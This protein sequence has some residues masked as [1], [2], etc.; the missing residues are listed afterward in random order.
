VC[1][2]TASM[3]IA[4][5]VLRLC[6]GQPAIG[7]E[8]P[9]SVAQ[10]RG[11]LLAAQAQHWRALLSCLFQTRTRIAEWSVCVWVG[12]AGQR[13]NRRR[14]RGPGARARPQHDAAGASHRGRCLPRSAM[15]QTNRIE[16]KRPSHRSVGISDWQR[17]RHCTGS[18]T[19]Q[20][21]GELDVARSAC[22]HTCHQ[23]ARCSPRWSVY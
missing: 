7:Y 6:A 8:R 22:T 11:Q 13:D 4:L 18:C 2:S 16:S 3:L 5:L 12:A 21:D 17:W 20:R 1:D 14:S 9:R 19:W 23:R 10:P 15:L